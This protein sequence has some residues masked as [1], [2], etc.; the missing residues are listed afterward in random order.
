MA[1]RFKDLEISNLKKT[2]EI[3]IVLK[4]PEAKK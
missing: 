2:M 1:R 4:T 3:T